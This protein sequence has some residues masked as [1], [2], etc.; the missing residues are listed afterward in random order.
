MHSLISG[1]NMSNLSIRG[2]DPDL[3][4]IDEEPAEYYCLIL[5]QLKNDGAPIP[6]N[7]IWIAAVA[8][9]KG[10]PLIQETST[11]PILRDCCLSDL[12]EKCKGGC[13]SPWFP[14]L[15]LGTRARQ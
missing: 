12:F 3:A 15:S 11:S 9:Q 7:D 13:K 6:N 5:D 2:I 8:F 4:T 10:M 14:S 1:A